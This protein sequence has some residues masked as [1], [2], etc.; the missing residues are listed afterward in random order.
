MIVF[1]LI[2]DEAPLFIKGVKLLKKRTLE[3]KEEI[4]GVVEGN[5]WLK[6]SQALAC[7][8]RLHFFDELDAKKIDITSEILRISK[9]YDN[10]NMYA[11]D[12]Y[13][14]EKPR[15]YQKKMLVYTY[16]FF[17]D[18]FSRGV[19]YYFTTGIAYTYNLVSFQVAKRL[20]V[21]HVSF[22]GIRI[23]N[24]TAVSFDVVNTFD[25]VLE[26]YKDFQQKEITEH[27]YESIS[28]FV[29]RP[30]QPNYMGNAINSSSLKFI[31][32]KEFFIRFKRYYFSNRHKY[33]LFTR[34]PFLLSNFRFKKIIKAKN[35]NFF[36]NKIFDKINYK[37]SYF[38]LA[39]RMQPEAS[40]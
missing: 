35:I 12:R 22:Y 5:R 20:G 9:T 26:C 7:V 3:Q 21:K 29:D 14:I 13:L 1:D 39:L 37:D 18:L 33:D 28:K 30:K 16:L 36:H 32:L 24:R 10:F 11:C 8:N 15:A 38:I 31:F 27:M 23:E 40:T 25:E 4:I 6:E 2:N 34:N 17:E 19:N